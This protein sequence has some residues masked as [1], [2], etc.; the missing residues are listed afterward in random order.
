MKTAPN[1]VLLAFKEWEDRKK[2]M[3]PLQKAGRA[4][5]ACSGNCNLTTCDRYSTNCVDGQ[6]VDARWKQGR[7]YQEIALEADPA[8]RRLKLLDSN[9]QPVTAQQLNERAK[10]RVTKEKQ[11]QPVQHVRQRIKQGQRM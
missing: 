8:N 3:E 10:E 9:R 4:T 6:I 1:R 7:N 5:S 11:E 2:E